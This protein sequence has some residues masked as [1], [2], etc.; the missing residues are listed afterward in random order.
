MISYIYMLLI[1]VICF[2]W[3]G[4]TKEQVDFFQMASN[5]IRVSIKYD[6]LYTSLVNAKK[7][8]GNQNC[9]TGETVSLPDYKIPYKAIIC[10]KENVYYAFYLDTILTEKPPVSLANDQGFSVISVKDIP[11]VCRG[12]NANN[13]NSYGRQYAL[14]YT[15]Q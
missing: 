15:T 7:L 2:L 5:N 9:A 6:Y 11:S 12:L 8:C 13:N 14:M 1:T 10:K 3:Q 4:I